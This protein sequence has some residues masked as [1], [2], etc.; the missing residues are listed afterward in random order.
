MAKNQA[1]EKVGAGWQCLKVKILGK[2]I[3]TFQQ[4]ED[5]EDQWCQTHSSQLDD[6]PE[7]DDTQQ[8]NGPT[9]PQTFLGNCLAES[10]SSECPDSTE[11]RPV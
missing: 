5:I 10:D 4:R 6:L 9:L 11:T 2:A 1:D 8:Q 7:E 3:Y